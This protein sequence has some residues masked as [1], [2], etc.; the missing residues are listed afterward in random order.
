VHQV[1]FGLGRLDVARVGPGV[2]QVAGVEQV[3]VVIDLV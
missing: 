3:E 2:D 1:G